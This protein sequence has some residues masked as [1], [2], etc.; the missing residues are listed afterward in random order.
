MNIFKNSEA[1]LHLAGQSS[2]ELS[3]KDP[4]LD[5]CK[6][7]SST[8]NLIR[9]AEEKQIQKFIYASSMSVY[10]KTSINPIKENHS[11]KPL[12]CYGN[13]KLSSEHYLRILGKKFNP[14]I[15][16][17]F[18]VYGPGQNMKNLNQGM[19]SIYLAQVL[20]NNKIIVK[21]SKKGVE[22]SFLLMTL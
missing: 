2:G 4:N 6:N 22:I 16:R 3:F 13:S 11:L 10:G 5:L 8:I 1:I 9:L 17:L 12:S 7:T 19:V 21:G 20:E 15:L 14:V 18:N